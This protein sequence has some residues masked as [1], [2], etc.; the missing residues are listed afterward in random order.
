MRLYEITDEL[1]EIEHQ[2]IESFGE[3]TPEIEAR[4]EKLQ[5]AR[6][7]KV[8]NICRL[9]QNLQR[10]AEAAIAEA[11]RLGE[12]AK[13]RKAGADRLKN[14]LRQE[15]VQ[16]GE[17]RY[18]TDLFRVSRCKNSRPSITPMDPNDPP[19]VWT[20]VRV[21]FDGTK[22]YQDLKDQGILPDEVGRFELEG[23]I[24]NRGE[25]LRIK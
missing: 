11:S 13:A 15:M 1:R 7:E 24:V 8:Q 3:L 2:L 23:V 12:L 9:V 21:E 17:Q 16:L 4:L 5:G 19:A 25:H 10:T 18:E 6:K 22:A 20:R 14:Y